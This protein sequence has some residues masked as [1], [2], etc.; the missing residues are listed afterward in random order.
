MRWVYIHSSIFV[1]DKTV[2]Q[3]GSYGDMPGGKTYIAADSRRIASDNDVGLI[4]RAMNFISG[5]D[6]DTGGNT[7]LQKRIK[8]FISDSDSSVSGNSQNTDLQQKINNY[9]ADS[10]PV[11]NSRLTNS[12]ISGSLSVI[13]NLHLNTSAQAIDYDFEI[14]YRLK[15]I[16]YELNQI[17]TVD[18]VNQ[19]WKDGNNYKP[20]YKQVTNV[21]EIILSEDTM[22]VRVYDIDNADMKGGWVMKYEDIKG[23]TPKEIQNKYA[24]SYTPKFIVDVYLKAGT[25]LNSGIANNLFGNDGGGIQ[26]DMQNKRVGQFFN[27]RL[28][29]ERA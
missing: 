16:D 26:F 4:N 19:W 24:L 15:S 6:T 10:S 29:K 13:D 7:D 18:E 11:E 8:R 20:P 14:D 22:F 12:D 3:S 21:K 1:A 28:I 23:L 5:K 27:E 2:L 17:K 25:K 9:L